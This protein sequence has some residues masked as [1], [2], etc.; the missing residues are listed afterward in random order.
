MAIPV[1]PVDFLFVVFPQPNFTGELAA[2]LQYLSDSGQITVLDLIFI[3]K[4]AEGNVTAVELDE[5]DDEAAD[6]F[7]A[8]ANE[9]EEIL[10]E[11]DIINFGA[12][13]PNDSAAGLLVFEN[14]W[15]AHFIGAMQNAG[16]EV[17]LS[18]RI[19]AADVAAALLEG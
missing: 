11:E 18:G 1:G 9:L 5:M 19:P 4:D 16:G 2:E 12:Q 10:V 7:T 17:V 14:T 6:P 13:M 8:A 15:A 3:Y